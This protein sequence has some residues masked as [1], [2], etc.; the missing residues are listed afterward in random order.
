M[1]SAENPNSPL[2]ICVCISLLFIHVPLN[3]FITRTWDLLPGLSSREDYIFRHR[4]NIDFEIKGS[5]TIMNW[6]LSLKLASLI[7]P[8]KN[9]CT[10]FELLSKGHVQSLITDLLSNTERDISKSDSK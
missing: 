4:S 8:Y 5:N 1:G 3:L 10:Q 6:T 2:Y 9:T 7:T